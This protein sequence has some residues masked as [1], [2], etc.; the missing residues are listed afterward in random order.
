MPGCP[1]D[2]E[3]DDRDREEFPDIGSIIDRILNGS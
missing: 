2:P 1:V 3:R